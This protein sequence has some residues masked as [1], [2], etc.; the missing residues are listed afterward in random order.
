MAT[1][2]PHGPLLNGANSSLA[3]LDFAACNAGTNAAIVRI[4]MKGKS[5]NTEAE[6]DAARV[7][8]S[9]TGGE[10]QMTRRAML[11]AV[12]STAAVLV[13]GA[14][15]PA[16]AMTGTSP[17]VSAMTPGGN[18]LQRMARLYPHESLTRSTRDLSGLWEFRLDPK[19]EGEAAG[20]HKSL[21]DTRAI[22][23]PASWNEIFD[24]AALYF[25]TAWYQ[26]EFRVDP[27]WRGR[28]IFLR[29]GAAS[30]RARVWL[31]GQLLGE[32]EGGHLPFE[33][34]VTG[35]VNER[36]PNR[37]VVLVDNA[38]RPDRVPAS[39][40]PSGGFNF[41]S[42]PAVTFDFFP[43]GGLHRPVLLYSTPQT[44]VED[45]TVH[46]DLAAGNG[47]VRTAIQ[48]G[49]GWN[50][51]A[52]V[53]IG[54]AAGAA[55]AA[56]ARVKVRAGRAEVELR[57]PGVRPWSPEDPYL[58][59]LTV[60]LEGVQSDEYV[61]PVGVRTITVDKEGLR[62]NG[63][64][65]F[66]T[67]F[68]KH[69]DFPIHGKGLDLPVLVRDYEL[70]KWIGANSFRTSHYPYSDD[71]LLLADRYGL[72][73]IAE[74]PA[75]SLSF[76]DPEPVIQARH[77]Q[78]ARALAEMHARDKNHPCVIAWSIAN[79]PGIGAG[80]NSPADRRA[81]TDRGTAYFKPLF[82][83]MRERD[84][85]RPV[86]LVSLGNG[87]DEWAGLGDFICT[88]LYFGW[89]TAGGQLDDVAR[90]MLETELDRLH[91]VHGKP[92]MLTEFGA[93]TNAGVHA[94]PATMWSEEYQSQMM[95]L[96]LQVIHA[97]SFV[98]GAHP[99][100]F[101]DFR[102]APGVL[103]AGGLNQKGVFTRERQPK[104]AA[105]TLRRLWR[106]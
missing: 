34:E 103:R 81:M 42:Y 101:A 65:L 83:D 85:A 32:H 31:D 27:A 89:Y 5:M 22:P 17:D 6:I 10:R 49:G 48:V 33:F 57:I 98:V 99:W 94:E 7:E 76:T 75:V 77:A 95:E 25:G 90:G 102:T 88:N 80:A 12:G 100:A 19:D 73:V 38:Q 36:V 3:A 4:N 71:A 62:L 74:S 44:A 54:G 50:G 29:F 78:H 21:S 61:L 56:Q 2:L 58:Y 11:G 43:Y 30:Y 51:A 105:H 53:S 55:V 23:V 97:R 79:E 91:S 72:L 93:D 104:L 9:V 37:L 15:A 63:K 45:L 87:P 68:G 8:Q 66:L 69:E 14:A 40:P 13:S 60:K 20:W 96:Y 1:E 41:S 70:L 84:P 39:A 47:I 35:L 92:V 86:V 59:S 46:T 26:K 52:V 18:A 82:D 24:D 64:P 16:L 67:G 28:R 106:T